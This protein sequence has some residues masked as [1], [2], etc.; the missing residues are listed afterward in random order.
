MECL[1]ELERGA[2]LE[3]Q[4]DEINKGNGLYKHDLETKFGEIKWLED[5]KLYNG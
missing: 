4:K 5:S 3:Q 2:F 1:M